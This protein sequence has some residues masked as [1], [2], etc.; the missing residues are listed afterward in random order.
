MLKPN[1]WICF[2]LFFSTLHANEPKVLV[3][4]DR[5]M[6]EPYASLLKGKKIGL[7]TNHTAINSDK[8]STI[9][10]FKTEAKKRSFQLL[11]F[12]GPEHGIDGDVHA[13]KGVQ[14]KDD[15][16]GIPIYSLHGETRRPTDEMLKGINLLVFDIQDIGS[17]S[18][19][20]STTLFY[21]M[22]E[23]AKK[24]I[25]V[26]VLDRP[27][28]LG[29]LIVDGPMLEDKL[30]SFVGYINIPYCHGMTIGE[31][32]HY[33]NEEY[34]VGCKLTVVPMKGWRRSMTF[35]DTG[36]TWI[37]TSPNIP[38]PDTTF[39]Y[40]TTGIIGELQLVSIGIGYT[41]PFKLIGAPW[42]N[43]KTLADNLNKQKFPGVHFE[44]FKYRP[45][46]GKFAHKDCQGVLILITNSSLYKPVSTQYLILGI[47]KNLY[48]NPF[49]QGLAKA[50][51]R[52]DMF[53]KVN[54]T[55][56]I[57]KILSQDGYSVWKL[58]TVHEKERKIFEKTR[59]KY[60]VYN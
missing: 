53:N 27:N 20:Y 57:F 46:Y 17:R 45:F 34:K 49:Q 28:P 41:L 58:I 4:A 15:A 59:Q 19:T 26:W 35:K 1:F 37:P 51:K 38:E 11:A 42:I 54:G 2:L 8:L 10:L 13:E 29:G 12:F 48:K 36:L 3:G 23:A 9:Q 24:G 21:A 43:G 6:H 60:L 7:I 44:P 50:Q 30:R 52:V 25:E 32:A 55:D 16:D 47:L 33:F 56:Q 14:S 39:Y 18:Y 40:P 22:E 5:V 31:L